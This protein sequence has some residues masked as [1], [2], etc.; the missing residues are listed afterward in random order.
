MST[1]ISPLAV[2]DPKA[3]LAGDVVVGPF[4]VVGPEV[5]IGAGTRLLSHVVIDGRTT[6]GSG[7]IIYPNSYLGGPPQDLKYKGE[8]TTLIIGNNNTIREGTTMHLGTV[9]GGGVT[10][11]GSNNLFMVNAHL[12]HDVTVGDRCILA[13]NSMM[14]GHVVLGNNVVFSAGAASHH[15][16]RISDYVFVGAYSKLHIDVPPFVKVH[17]DVIWDTNTVGLKRAGFS[18]GDIQAIE[19]AVRRLFISKKTPFSKAIA[20]YDTANGINPHVKKMIE[21]LRQRDE[22]KHGRYLEKFRGK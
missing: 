18:E 14:A 21:F 20:E 13:N 6:I 12:G 9:Q 4:C 1:K 15:F 8:P 7:N 22:G 10:R 3:Q 2:V 17:N 19:G 11:V 5:T 16:V